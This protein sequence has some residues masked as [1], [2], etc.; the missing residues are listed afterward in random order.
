VTRALPEICTAPLLL[1]P[2]R[3]GDLEPYAALSGDARV[4]EYY[5]KTTYVFTFH[6]EGLFTF[7]CMPHQPERDRADSGPAKQVRVAVV[8]AC[9]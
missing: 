2:W 4:M 7:C 9:R 5:R 1:R 3:A 8:L 6:E